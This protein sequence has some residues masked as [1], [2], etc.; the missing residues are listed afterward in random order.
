MIKEVE[1]STTAQFSYVEACPL[2]LVSHA[3]DPK[4]Q[5]Q[6]DSCSQKREKAFAVQVFLLSVN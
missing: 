4:M 3:E 2:Y 5:E 6:N 1:V